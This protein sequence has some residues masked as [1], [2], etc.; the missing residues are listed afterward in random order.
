MFRDV[1]P[2]TQLT[3]QEEDEDQYSKDDP[4]NGKVTC[5]ENDIN[6]PLQTAYISRNHY[7]EYMLEIAFVRWT[8]KLDWLWGTCGVVKMISLSLCSKLSLGKWTTW[9]LKFPTKHRLRQ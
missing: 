9:I 5:A 3:R 7:A 6:T 1:V 4:P 8:K 2:S